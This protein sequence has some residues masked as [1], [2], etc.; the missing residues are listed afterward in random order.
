MQTQKAFTGFSSHAV[1]LLCICYEGLIVL[2]P[3]ERNKTNSDKNE[4]SH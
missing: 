2:R 3:H 1:I 4:G